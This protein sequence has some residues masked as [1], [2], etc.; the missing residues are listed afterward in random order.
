MRFVFLYLVIIVSLMGEFSHEPIS[1]APQYSIDYVLSADTSSNDDTG[2]ILPSTPRSTANAFLH[3]KQLHPDYALLFEFLAE[4]WSAKLYKKLV[5]SGSTEDWYA[6]TSF[7]PSKHRVCGWHDS[8]LLY[9]TGLI[10]PA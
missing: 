5:D 4:D 7:S 1:S 6:K 8:N 9:N 3:V 2:E 10:Q